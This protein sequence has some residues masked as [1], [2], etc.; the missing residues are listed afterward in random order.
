MK[1][2]SAKDMHVM[3]QKTIQEK[4]FSNGE[5]MRTAGASLASATLEY[6]SQLGKNDIDISSIIILAGKG[7]NG[8]DAFV[9]AKLLFETKL[10]TIHLH[11]MVKEDSL[12]G[13]ALSMFRE[14]P[15]ELKKNIRYTL[16]ENDL[17]KG[18]PCLILDGLLGTGFHGE[19]RGEYEKW[20]TLAN[21]S[22][23]H[24]L[25]IDLPSGMDADTGKGAS[26]AIKADL[27]ICMANPKK[28]MLTPEGASLCGR[29]R[30][31][32]IG[33]CEKFTEE[34]TD[35]IPCT[36]LADVKKCFGKEMNDIHKN[37]RGHVLILG[38][39][40]L[41]SG[42]PLLAGEAA[43][44][45]G[46]GLVSILVPEKTELFGSIPK[47]LMLRHIEGNKDGFFDSASIKEV[48]KLAEKVNSIVTGPGMGQNAASLDFLEYILQ[49]EKTVLFDADA[50][51]LLAG[52]A[53]LFT[54]K[55]CTA[56]LTPHEGEMKRLENA[57]HLDSTLSRTERAI[58][59]AEK[60]SSY[61]ILKG[62][63]SVIASPEGRYTVN[64]SGSPAL[65]T[66]GSGDVLAGIC[67]AMVNNKSQDVFSALSAAVFLHGLAGELANPSGSRGVTADDLLSYIAP[68]MRKISPKA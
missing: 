37:S 2:V 55:K 66:A 63:R 22:G 1:A 65:A 30:I 49:Q 23:H 27:T 4:N 62:P 39:S 57:F 38:G 32:D 16:T 6:I 54:E 31:M 8:G 3:D 56:I 67:G 53:A 52:K 19:L 44:R 11:C 29:L 18:V 59:L 42:A 7:N 12:T 58:L 26:A 36:A 61:V 47:A 17:A 34:I 9:A 51:N 41:Y 64:L 40:S 46:A 20:I 68:A 33:I 10:F 60:S 24:I 15:E 43:L 50:L 14:L 13:D 21:D 48:Q 35:F 45:T 5:L 28:G 25:A